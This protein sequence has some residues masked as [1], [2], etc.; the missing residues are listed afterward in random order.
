MKCGHEACR[1][2]VEGDD[3]FCSEHCR[4]HAAAPTGH[5]EHACECG[6]PAC[7][8]QDEGTRQTEQDILEAF[9]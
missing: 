6:H 2:T 1:C 7:E 8:E 3:R 4:D 5:G 9:E